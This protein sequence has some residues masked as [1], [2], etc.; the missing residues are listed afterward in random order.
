MAEKRIK[1]TF[2]LPP[3]T[4]LRIESYSKELGL[5][6][7]AFISLMVNQIDSKLASVGNLE[8]S[9][10]KKLEVDTR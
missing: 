2:T 5:S 3:Q 9:M 4:V 10:Q 7:S 8:K 6:Q 1:K